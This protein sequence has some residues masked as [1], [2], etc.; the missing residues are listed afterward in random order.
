MTLDGPCICSGSIY[1]YDW[2]GG[3][4]CSAAGAVESAAMVS[5]LTWSR[6]VFEFSYLQLSLTQDPATLKTLLSCARLVFRIFFSLN[7]PGLT[8]VSLL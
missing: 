4:M 6:H 7:A 5:M 1:D 8:P 2:A 3:G